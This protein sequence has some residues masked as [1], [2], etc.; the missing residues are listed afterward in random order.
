MST[1]DVAPGWGRTNDQNVTISYFVFVRN[2]WDF[3]YCIFDFFFFYSFNFIY[4]KYV[5]GHINV[6][7]EIN[8]EIYS[9]LSILQLI[10]SY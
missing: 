2:G 6:F 10:S 7:L 9:L 4:V 8:V 1:S 3:F 5:F